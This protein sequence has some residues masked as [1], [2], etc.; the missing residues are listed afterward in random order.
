MRAMNTT[1]LFY[2][3]LLSIMVLFTACDEDSDD[4][5]SAGGGGDL[6]CDNGIMDAFET[7]IDCDTD[8]TTVCPPCEFCGDGL[9]SSVL[10]DGDVSGMYE[11]DIDCGTPEC[12]PCVQE[13]VVESI[14]E[15]GMTGAFRD[16]YSWNLL[17]SASGNDTLEL[18]HTMYP[19]LK[20]ERYS[21]G[22]FGPAHLKITA[23]H[24]IMTA[25]SGIYVKTIMMYLPIPENVVPSNPYLGPPITVEMANAA[26]LAPGGC[27]PILVGQTFPF[28]IYK[29]ELID[30]PQMI[31]RC[32][33]SYVD[34]GDNSEL[35]IDHLLG[36]IQSE[37]YVKGEINMGS[38]LYQPIPLPGSEDVEGEIT[39]V[40]FKLHYPFL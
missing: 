13:F 11:F 4:D 3:I 22:L 21:A 33:F 10:L 6:F 40:S 34:A 31:S 23:N 29:E 25:T 30:N 9:L 24:G 36:Y 19:G 32:F 16:Q 28:I 26:P 39:G 35:S 38:L 37:Y 7:G 15:V 5:Q 14:G 20:V 12:G 2:T 17:L 8:T 27:S 18:N 1:K